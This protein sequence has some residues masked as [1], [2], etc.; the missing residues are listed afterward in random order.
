M[1]LC[2]VELMPLHLQA[3]YAR[4]AACEEGSIFKA[5]KVL[6]REKRAAHLTLVL[7]DA[8]IKTR[9]GYKICRRSRRAL[10]SG[11]KLCL[12]LSSALVLMP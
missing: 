12:V 9:E 6:R 5:L 1:R 3:L 2:A 10:Q 4:S 7:Q 11:R 8:D